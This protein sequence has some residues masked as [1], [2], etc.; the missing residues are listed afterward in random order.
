[1]LPLGVWQSGA[2][3][4]GRNGASYVPKAR[5]YGIALLS[6]YVS[7]YVTFVPRSTRENACVGVLSDSHGS[8]NGLLKFKMRAL[9]A[10]QRDANG[11]E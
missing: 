9:E 3:G 1:M 8:C 10:A 4:R 11:I 2:G 5:C 6:I 7:I